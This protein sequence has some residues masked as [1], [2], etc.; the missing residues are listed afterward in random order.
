MPIRTVVQELCD[1]CYA[2]EGG[3]E[4]PATDRLRFSWQ[5]RDYVLVA[6][7]LHV[8]PVRDELQRLSDI[9]T[10]EPRARRAGA[11]DGLRE[12]R[13]EVARRRGAAGAGRTLFSQLDSEEKGRFRAWAGLPT[14]R[15]IADERVSDW[16]KAG[17]P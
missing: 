6:C 16:V 17:R 9:A 4:S 8:G 11:G 7:S 15:R 14:A 2:D 5:G 1:V 10:P 12:Q 13:P 3:R